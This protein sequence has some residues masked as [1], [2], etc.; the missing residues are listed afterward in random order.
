LWSTW[1]F[2]PDRYKICRI[3]WWYILARVVNIEYRYRHRY[4][5]RYFFGRFYRYFD[6]DTFGMTIIFNSCVYRILMQLNV[7]TSTVNSAEIYWER[8]DQ[9]YLLNFTPVFTFF[10]L[11]DRSAGRWHHDNQVQPFLSTFY[12]PIISFS[13]R[14]P[15]FQ[16]TWTFSSQSTLNRLWPRTAQYFL[17]LKLSITADVTAAVTNDY[18]SSQ[19]LT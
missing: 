6:I 12:R 10:T 18:F 5:R 3:C 17:N 1:S 19:L 15:D 14:L 13:S 16:T 8:S 11:C 7:D 4:Y 9:W 2:A